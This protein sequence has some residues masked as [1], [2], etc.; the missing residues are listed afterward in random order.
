MVASH[1]L[2]G[3]AGLR[4][5]VLED[6]EVADE[7]KETGFVEETADDHF[8]LRH[9][10]RRQLLAVDA[11]P[12]HEALAIRANGA[13]AGQQA[14]GN[15]SH[16]IRRKKRWHLCFVRLNLTEGFPD[17]GVFIG[18]VFELY[19]SERKSVYEKNDVGPSLVTIF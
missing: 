17:V 11:P 19:D 6:Y 4:G 13:D 2:D 7:L 10:H 18:S 9:D 3:S 12:G 16:S 5:I 8:Q 1:L 14:I 15:Y